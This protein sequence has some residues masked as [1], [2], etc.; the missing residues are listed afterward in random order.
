MNRAVTSADVV[1]AMD[2]LANPKD[3]GEYGFYYSVIKGWDAYAAARRRRSRAS[4]RPT[5]TDRLQPDR[6]DRRLPLSHGDACDRPDPGR[7]GQVLRRA[8]ANQY[9]RDLISTARYMIAGLLRQL[10]RVR[11]DQAGQRLPAVERDP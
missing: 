4:R 6:A 9:G 1:Y 5:T 10:H 3:G 2:R 7:G 8:K 11:V